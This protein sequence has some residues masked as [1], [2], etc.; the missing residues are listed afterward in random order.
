MQSTMPSKLKKPCAHQSCPSLAA[1]GERYCDKHKSANKIYYQQKKRIN[2]ERN[3]R[4]DSRR[5]RRLRLIYLR[6]NPLCVEC[7]KHKELVPATEVHHIIDVVRGGSDAEENLEALCKSCHSRKTATNKHR[8][9]MST[10]V[11]LL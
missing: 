3:L 6:A 10:L 2:S 11:N 7:E 1:S 8:K 4:E 5:W 9:H